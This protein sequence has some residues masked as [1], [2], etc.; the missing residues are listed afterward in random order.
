MLGALTLGVLDHSP[1]AL[2]GAF[3]AGTLIAIIAEALLP[4]AFHLSPRFSGTL[5]AGGF[6]GALMLAS[7]A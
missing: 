1:T 2:I 7:S 5:A 6:A 3:A 4:E